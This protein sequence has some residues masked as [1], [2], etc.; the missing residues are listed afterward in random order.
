[1]SCRLTVSAG[2]YGSFD[3][4]NALDCNTVLIVAVDELIF[5]LTNFVNE[6]TKLIGNIRD[7]VVTAFSPDGELLLDA[8]KCGCCGRNPFS[9]LRQPPSSLALPIPYFASRSS[10]SSPIVTTSWPGLA[11]MRRRYFYGMHDLLHLKDDQYVS[12][13]RRAHGHWT[14]TLFR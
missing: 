11:R 14:E 4:A 12:L 2:L 7:I 3:V 10:P 13:R 8:V 5:K 6:D 1:M 9:H